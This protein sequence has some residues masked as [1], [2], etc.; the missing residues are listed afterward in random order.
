MN[1]QSKK[2]FIVIFIIVLIIFFISDILSLIQ[3]N[4][5]EIH[6]EKETI[7]KDENIQL[8]YFYGEDC[9]SCQQAAPYIEQLENDFPDLQIKKFE[10]FYNEENK[11]ILENKTKERGK[12]SNFVPTVIF[13]EEVYVGLEGVKE[14]KENIKNGIIS[15]GNLQDIKLPFLGDININNYS[16]LTKTILISIVDGFNPCS[17]WIFT[18][19]LGLAVSVCSRKK[20]FIIGI[21]F[22]TVVSLIYGMFIMGVLNIFVYVKNIFIIRLI[23]SLFTIIFSIVNIKDYFFLKKGFSFTIPEKY[24]PKIIKKIREIIFQKSYFNIILTTII[25]AGGVSIIELPCTAGFP[26]LWGNIV[27]MYNIEFSQYIILLLVYLLSY[28]SIEIIIFII[29]VTTLR[30]F[31]LSTKNG[32]ILKL[33]GG[34]IMLNLGLI[35]VFKPELMNSVYYVISIFVLSFFVFLSVLFFNKSYI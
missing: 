13:R 28:L 26:V 34:I 18:F 7:E 27:S 6:N 20:V 4:Q 29:A 30:K 24:K 31:K 14:V 19:L 9:Y 5:L 32:R 2:V 35:L 25:F 11:K 1:K 8:Y 17:L 10:V 12:N 23:L 21:I 3:N 22:L 33:F 15:S 16:V